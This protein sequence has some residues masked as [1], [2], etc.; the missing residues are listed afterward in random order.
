MWFEHLM[1]VLAIPEWQI[2]TRYVCTLTYVCTYM[3]PLLKS[4]TLCTYTWFK[5]NICMHFS[6]FL[7]FFAR[8]TFTHL[9]V[10]QGRYW[11]T[12]FTTRYTY[13]RGRG[14]S[15][16]WRRSYT[17]SGGT[18]ACAGL[19]LPFCPRKEVRLEV[20]GSGVRSV[21]L[22]CRSYSPIC[23]AWRRWRGRGEQ[24]ERGGE[25]GESEEKVRG[26]W[27]EQTTH[28]HAGT[29][30]RMHTHT[31]TDT[32]TDTHTH[33]HTTHTHTHTHTHT[34]HTHTHT[35]RHTHTA[36]TCS[37]LRS[38]QLTQ[39]LYNEIL[40]RPS[41]VSHCIY[42]CKTQSECFSCAKKLKR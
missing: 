29:H 35:H 9:Q 13:G 41:W 17:N 30:A 5:Y 1:S 14:T 40:L 37:T 26:E 2:V 18:M 27:V 39:L 31:H 34:T 7:F 15:L 4:Y 24:W 42:C 33:T 25:W 6:I 22:E 16:P 11:D 36:H 19:E 3:Y 23:H 21:W 8:F 12:P 32:H 20:A 10:S 38:P 28:M